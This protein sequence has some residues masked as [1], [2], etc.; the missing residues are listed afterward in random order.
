MPSEESPGTVPERLIARVTRGMAAIAGVTLLVMLAVTVAN[1]L[2]R[3]FATPYHGTFEVVGLLAVAVN[4]LALGEAQRRKT[5]VS[6]DIVMSRTPMRIQLAMGAA[7]TLVA[8]ALFIVVSRQ[9]VDY[10]LN[11]RAEG[12]LTESLR[13]P[14]W[15]LALVLALGVVG[16]VLALLSDL[17]AIGSNLRADVPEGIW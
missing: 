14:F 16:L 2:A 13:V 9:L 17:I 4:G 8:V 12:A 3:A 11:L 10:G 1:M 6:V 15:P 7:V 5:H